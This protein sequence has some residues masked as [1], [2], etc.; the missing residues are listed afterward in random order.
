MYIAVM[1]AIRALGVGVLTALALPAVAQAADIYKCVDA[2]GR[3][4]Y[5]NDKRETVGRKCEVIA[6][7]I[8]VAP[9]PAKP[10]AKPGA[11]PRESATE[12]SA[13][14]ARQREILERELAAEQ[15]DLEKARQALAEQEAV[16]FG[17]ERNYARVLER[18]QPF[19]DRVDTHEKNIEALQRELANLNR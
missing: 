3:A 12:R 10:A 11:F 4:S 2:S 13:A 16:R 14:L 15:Q 7:Q 5:T 17:D 6:S 19:R 8:N 1:R 9:A 18:L